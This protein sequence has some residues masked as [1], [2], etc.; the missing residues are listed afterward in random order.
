MKNYHSYVLEA[1]SSL[2]KNQIFAEAELCGTSVCPMINGAT[3]FYRHKSECGI[4]VVSTVF[5]LPDNTS[6]SSYEMRI[7]GGYLPPI[8][9]RNESHNA[10]AKG[11]KRHMLSLPDIKG[12][13]AFEILGRTVS[14]LPKDPLHPYKNEALACGLILPFAACHTS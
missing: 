4:F 5:G 12:T 14:I 13:G 10:I 1:V 8:K 11:L 6:V 3:V 7:W 9:S 2:S